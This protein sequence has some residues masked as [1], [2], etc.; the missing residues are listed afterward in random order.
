[1]ASTQWVALDSKLRPARVVVD[2]A[3][4][5]LDKILVFAVIKLPYLWLCLL[6]GAALGSIGI[7]FCYPRLRLPDSRNFQ[8]FDS[9]HPFERYDVVYRDSFWFE[10]LKKVMS[11]TSPFYMMIY[12]LSSNKIH[13]RK[14]SDCLSLNVFGSGLLLL[15]LVLDFIHHMFLKCLKNLKTLKI[16]TF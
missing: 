13:E 10:R 15:L 4:A 9:Q 1:V 2:Q 12:C 11:F 3:R 5:L 7:V 14:L 16:T 6:G 8:L